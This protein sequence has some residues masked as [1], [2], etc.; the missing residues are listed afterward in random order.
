MKCLFCM[1]WN[2]TN[3]SFTRFWMAEMEGF[4]CKTVLAFSQVNHES[5]QWLFIQHLFGIQWAGHQ[6]YGGIN[7]RASREWKTCIRRVE[8]WVVLLS[9]DFQLWEVQVVRAA[10]SREHERLG[11]KQSNAWVCACS[12]KTLRHLFPV[13]GISRTRLFFL[14]VSSFLSIFFGSP[15]E[16]LRELSV[17]FII[18]MEILH[19]WN[20]LVVKLG[21]GSTRH[22]R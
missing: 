17:Y 2:P 8:K 19:L 4:H 16:S 11:R 7:G 9:T 6:P 12:E 10:R 13:R 3:T 5:W 18:P 20:I 15:K 21:Q 22:S 1:S 14:S